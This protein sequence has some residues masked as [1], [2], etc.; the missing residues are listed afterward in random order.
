MSI[1]ADL[2]TYLLTLGTVTTLVGEGGLGRIRPDRLHEGETLPAVIMQVD[3]E[4]PLN[5][6]DGK[7]G[8]VYADVTLI[9]RAQEKEDARTLAEAIRVNGTDPG[10]GLA[11][12][13]G[14]AGDSTIDA[15]LEDQNTS[16]TPAADGSDQGF[17]DVFCNYVITYAET[18]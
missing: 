7:G 2:R 4:R 3:N 13:N 16:F 12:Y 6:L 9:C 14:A 1:E 10:T 11:G 17:Y 5:T 18:V 8:R 15:W